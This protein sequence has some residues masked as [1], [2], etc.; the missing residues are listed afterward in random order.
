MLDT[1]TCL[2]ADALF[3]LLMDKLKGFYA[4]RKN[5]RVQSK[6]QRYEIGDFII[7][8]GSVT[9]GQSQGFKGV[10]VEVSESISCIVMFFPT[11]IFTSEY[12]SYD[13]IP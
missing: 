11:N 12:R 4:P 6:G 13:R 10:L 2:V 1:G 7:K 3:N 8:I 5:A 9:L